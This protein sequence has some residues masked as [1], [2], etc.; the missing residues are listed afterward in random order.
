MLLLSLAISLLGC[1]PHTTTDG[2]RF[3][4]TKK[5]LY[6][7]K[8]KYLHACACLSVCVSTYLYAAC[9]VAAADCCHVILSRFISTQTRTV[10]LREV[11]EVDMAGVEGGDQM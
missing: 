1:Q 3:V 2:A 7:W 10:P 8:R 5:Y 11:L 6:I 9:P 4:S